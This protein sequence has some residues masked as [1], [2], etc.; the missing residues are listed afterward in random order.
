[1]LSILLLRFSRDLEATIREGFA[2]WSLRARR[3]FFRQARRVLI[4][5]EHEAAGGAT[6][7]GLKHF[8]VA[9]EAPGVAQ[10]PHDLAHFRT[11]R[12]R[13]TRAGP[14]TAGEPRP[15]PSGGRVA[16]C[17]TGTGPAYRT[18][19]RGRRPPSRVGPGRGGEVES[20]AVV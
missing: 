6:R 12:R 8:R 7:K 15:G 2:G 11:G 10:P 13:S 20:T 9:G 4:N 1:M 5:A 16:P 3:A 14:A 18:P 17:L 19:R